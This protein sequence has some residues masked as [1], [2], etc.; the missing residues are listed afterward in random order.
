MIVPEY[1]EHEKRD[2]A[3]RAGEPDRR[4][5]ARVVRLVGCLAVGRIPAFARACPRPRN[6]GIAGVQTG[7]RRGGWSR[8]DCIYLDRLEAFAPGAYLGT[9]LTEGLARELDSALDERASRATTLYRW[10][11]LVELESYLGGTFESRTVP[12][13]G[14]RGCGLFS[15]RTDGYA[16]ERPVRMAVPVDDVVRGKL[17][18]AVYTA[19]PGLVR[20]REDRRRKTPRQTRPNAGWRTAPACPAAPAFAWKAMYS[21]RRPIR[22]NIT[23]CLNRSGAW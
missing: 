2:A 23:T 22:G 5:D 19:L 12:G 14:R 10:M 18:T 9:L 6:L 15:L 13:K 4:Q 7:S 8:A 17:R 1:A 21:T 3:H 11:D 20:R 16:L